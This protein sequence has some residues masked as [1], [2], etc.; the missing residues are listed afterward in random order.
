[1][2]AA[3]K[4][5][6]Q[7]NTDSLRFPLDDR[8]S[9]K[10]TYPN[11]NSFDLSDTSIIHQQIQYDP[12]TNRYYIFEK[13]GNTNF[14]QP[15]YLTFDEYSKLRAKQEEDNYFKLRA[16]ALDS[17]NR[18]TTRPKPQVYNTLFDRIFGVNNVVS[19]TLN[20]TSNALHK[21]SNIPDLLKVKVQTQGNLELQTGYS[22]QKTLNPTLPEN[23]RHVGGFDFKMN[24]NLNVIANIGDKLKLPFNYNT[25]ANFDFLNK[26]KLSYKGMDDEII[27]SIEA[28]NISFQSRGTLMPSAQNLF[29]IKTQLQFGRLSITAAIANQS[30]QIQSQQL[31]GGSS[32]INFNKK[33]D[34]YDENRNF[35]LAQYFKNNYNK[36]MSNLPVVNSQVQIQRME[37]WITNRSGY[38]TDTRYI[39]GLADLGENSPYNSNVSSLTSNPLP[40]N[41]AN[42]L[43]SFVSNAT[44]DP[45]QISNILQNKGLNAVD[46]YEKVYARK[47]SSSEYYF[48]PQVGFIILNNIQ[49]Q[50][51]DVLAVAY[52]YTYNGRAY[53]VGEFSQDVSVDSVEGIQKIL[54][55]KLLKATAARVKLPIW[56]LMMKN[57]YSLGVNSVAQD[58]FKLNVLYQQPSGGINPYLPE[59]S[60]AMNGKTLLNILKLD[61]LNSRNDPQ[62]DGVF[63]FIDSLTILPQY[64][65][66]IFP[67][68]Q[69]FGRD[70]DSLAFSGVSTSIKQKYLYPQLY[71]SIKAIAQTYANL[72]RFYAQGTAKG[73][74]TSNL[75][76]MNVPPGS[77]KVTAGGQILQEGT[78]YIVDYSNGGNVRIINQAII[79][80]NIPVNISYE[81]NATFGIQ[82]RGFLGLRFDYAYS[83]KFSFGGGIVRLNERPFF[84]KMNYGEDPMRNTMYGLDF[85]YKSEWNGLTRALNK[86]PFYSTKAKSYITAYGEG[87][88]FKP[89]HPPQIGKGNN[90]AV[91]ID[92]F[93]GTTSNIDLRYPAISW[94]LAATPQ[95]TTEFPEATLS[96]NLDYGK[97]RAKLAWYNIEPNLQDKSASNNPLSGNLNELSDPRVR[98]VYTNELYPQQTTGITNTQTVTFDMAYYPTEKGP[99]NYESNP[100]Q[101]DANGKLINP[102]NR[103][104]GITRSLDQTDFETNNIVY[105][106]FL[107]QDPFIKNPASTGGKLRIDLGDISEDVLRD[108]KHSYENGLNAPNF[109]AG[110]DSSNWG[111]V[112]LN[113]VQT[114]NAFSNNA[115]DRPFQDVG[116]DGL[117]DDS[118]RVKRNDY[119]TQLAN[120]FGAGSAIYQKAIKD[121]SGDD[122]TWYRDATYNTANTGIL[123]R[124]KNY[125]GTDGNSPVVSGNST[126]I[127]A[128]TLYPDNED[129][130]HDNTVNETEQYFEYEIN[131]KPGMNSSNN[132][133]IA[134]V[135]PVSVTYANGSKGTENWYL[136]QIPIT[137]YTSKVGSISDFQSIRFIRTYLTGFTD[138]VVLRFAS[139]SLVRD[140]WRQFQYV[141]D[142]TGS[143]TPLTSTATNFNVTSVSI[144][145]NSS[146]TPV[147]YLIPPGIE[148]VQQLSNN[149]INL[150]QNEQSLSMQV[151]NLADG[152]AR[153]VIKTVNYDFRNYGKL[154]MFAHAETITGSSLNDNDLNLVV[155][156]G[157]D[158]LSNYYEV[159]IPLKVTP[160]GSY[161][162]SQDTIVWPTANNLDF[163]LQDLINLKLA[164]NNSGLSLTNIYRQF[165]SGKSYAIM[166]NPNLGAVTGILIGVEN[167]KS[168]NVSPLN[169]EVWVDELRLSNINEQGAYAATGRVDV[170]LADLGKASVSVSTHTQ[171]F[172]TIDSRINDRMRDNSTELDAS[173]SIDAGK[174]VPKKARLSIP[175]YASYT[176]T[177][178]LPQYDPYSLDISLKSELSAA[179]TKA[180]RDSIR[181]AAMDK[182]IIKTINFTNVRVMPKGKLHLWS[183]SNFDASYS[184]TKFTEFSPEIAN[185]TITKWRANLGYTFSPQIKFHQPFKKVIKSNSKWF[186]LVKD[187]NFNLK[188][189]LLSFR[190]DVNRQFGQYTP[191]IINTDLTSEKIT[192]VDTTFDKYF[193]FDRYYNMRWNLTHSINLDFSATNNAYVDEPDGF[194]NTKAKRDSVWH[195]FIKGGRNVMYQQNANIGYELPLGKFPVTDFIRANY[196]YTTSYDWVAASRVALTLGNIIENSQGNNITTDFDLTRLYNKWKWLRTAQIN[197]QVKKPTQPV[198]KNDKNFIPMNS[199]RNSN[200]TANIDV[201]PPPQTRYDATHDKNGNKLYGKE[202]REALKKWRQQKRDARLAEKLKRAAQTP[203]NEK[204]GLEKA[205]IGLLTM[206]KDINVEYSETYHSRIPGW[207]DSTQFLG[208]NWRSMEPGLDYVFGKQPDTSWLNKKAAKGLI[209]R[210][211]TFNLL[212]RQNFEQRFKITAQLE[213]VRDLRITLNMEKSFSKEYSELFKDTTNT[214]IAQQHLSPYASGSF[215]VSYISFNTLFEKRNPNEISST[216]QRFEDNRVIISRRMGAANPYSFVPTTGYAT[217]YG[218]TSQNVLIP[219]FLA[220]Y[221]KKSPYTIGLVGETNGD[222][223]SN[224][225]KSIL[226]KPN[227]QL[228]YTGL[229][230]IPA[231]ASV[232][233]SFSLSHGY[234]STLSMNDFGSALSY[235]DPLHLGSPG[236]ID[237]TSGNFI[238]FFLVPNLTIQ[239]QFTPLLGIS[240]T[241]KNNLGLDLRY[242]KSRTLS[243]SLIDYQLSETNS[244][245]WTIGAS[246]RKKGL[247]LPFQLPF[248]TGRKLIN[249]VTFRLDFS[250]RDDLTTNSTLNAQNSYATGGQKVIRINPSINYVLNNRISLLLY[251]DQIRT[252]PY[253][254]TSS[255]TIQTQG[256]V[257]VTVS[258]NNDYSLK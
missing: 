258:L 46:D 200:K 257:K 17:L 122:Y 33:L 103:W 85:T 78:D 10:F 173:L 246:W 80:S 42:N 178:V 201:P 244:T 72:D 77:V 161:S 147:N 86:L 182:T 123:G 141:L 7:S 251:F 204:T 75:Y 138:S 49:L 180:I 120:N 2:V 57:V 18:K 40:S 150:L 139:F 133:F 87:A 242:N 84:T 22:G 127:A 154:S 203:S 23:S 118:E 167:A 157:Q 89:G 142:T 111:N 211:S 169:A 114:T 136:F 59:A 32:L 25:L 30:S 76:A 47:L 166:G 43:Y 143:Y 79:N 228:T 140:A 195:N 229:T 243:L 179:K 255:P 130:N 207:M 137:G 129:L 125:N 164:R 34:D 105:V 223:K 65:K 41:N 231:L 240:F 222:I 192:S 189:S 31:Q 196:T 71:D 56:Q 197:N 3:N 250:L 52:Q 6:S 44:R 241:T 81:N 210:D 50:P 19:K 60:S 121:P 8:R 14:R 162:A 35:L 248:A 61:R 175:M 67:V 239:E 107:L 131:L 176:Q 113:P 177:N 91:Y 28:G 245:G 39:V 165:V 151:Y 45:S 237:S 186:S 212:Y 102:Q 48:N 146:R 13:V 193:K 256:G 145:Q 15:T 62:P 202:K 233:N 101:M 11:K 109:P 98:M 53:Q 247:Q 58:G 149:G 198:Y 168:G 183:I 119:L 68:L 185:N 36:A 132:P 181:N 73:N 220:A 54:Y 160:P 199:G 215:S 221:T 214:G 90:G 172:G 194:L 152:D 230:K 12:V 155:R 236:F 112:P 224:P 106:E 218:Y 69:P 219:A 96:D 4:V 21:Y 93:E 104:G 128:S 38:T 95:G 253:I 70:L 216:F 100:T 208:Q 156:I 159:R 1:M 163:N 83:K 213:P 187:F 158:F 235:Y 99:Y 238:P 37:V 254:S 82:Q 249:D 88:Y 191:R 64:G 209:S 115:E 234:S 225:F 24:T 124:Y 190:A 227:W 188:P 135:Q 184:Y 51:D 26:I 110:Q 108:G 205:V 5:L 126:L 134:Q 148:R 97:N 217:G 116:L 92:D 144:E 74:N 153:A 55:L 9:D 63:D 171:G 252:T 170:T 117:S 20:D 27:R 232:F 206:V 16:A 66:I 174:L 29:G 226:P 94:A